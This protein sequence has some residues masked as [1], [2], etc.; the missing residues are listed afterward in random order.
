MKGATSKDTRG[1]SVVQRLER[2]HCAYNGHGCV[3]VGGDKV[4]K[5]VA[6]QGAVVEL[7]IVMCA[8]V[9]VDAV[10]LVDLT[11]LAAEKGT[12]ERHYG[13]MR[14]QRVLKMTD[15]LKSSCT[16]GEEES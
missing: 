5:G 10:I 15:A 13:M 2:L 4:T 14:C 11:L 6:G 1:E 7:G 3:L 16:G 8:T 9:I 12:I